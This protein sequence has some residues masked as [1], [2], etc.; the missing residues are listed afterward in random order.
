MSHP[1]NPFQAGAYR[2]SMMERVH[3]GRPAAEVL[4]EELALGHAR[5]VL[6]VT[7]RSLRESP[8]LAGLVEGLSTRLAGVYAGVTAHSPRVCAVEGAS[9][10]R[11][12]SADLLVA[13]GGGSVIDATKGMLLC[14]R[15]GYTSPQEME[16][17]ANDRSADVSQRPGDADQWIRMIAVP[18]TLSGAEF[19]ASAGLSDPERGLK[20]AFVAAMQM[21]KAVI[22]DPAM[23]LATPLDLLRA[24]G[25]KAVDHAVERMTST[26]ANAYSDAVSE[27]ALRMLHE[28]LRGL[29]RNPDDLELRS[30]LQFGMFMSLRGSAAGVAVNVSHA[31]GHVLGAHAG[32]PHGQTTGVVLPS[33]LAW[34]RAETVEAQRRVAAALGGSDGDA[35]SA[36]RELVQELGLP[37]RLRDVGVRRDDFPAIAT[38]TMH[39]A[40]LRNSRKP[41][42]SSADVQEILELAW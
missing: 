5:R 10:A 3:W 20:H 13:V 21:P 31:I 23:T 19:A 36:V 11:A 35:T 6:L 33:V 4:L 15:H 12:S 42:G 39:E 17:H 7:N 41:V 1:G 37:T 28:G 18:T 32:V 26:T 25:L 34:N 22:L 2:S 29:D 30:R 9:Q 16:P 38:K 8:Q 27:V 40:L 14:L 24:T